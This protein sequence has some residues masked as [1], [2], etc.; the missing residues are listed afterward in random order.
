MDVFDVP[1]SSDAKFHEHHH[2]QGLGSARLSV[3]TLNR[4]SGSYGRI[5]LVR[6]RLGNQ[7]ILTHPRNHLVSAH[8]IHE[9]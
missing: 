6:I 7:P 8:P 5:V 3:D 9:H 1:L 4:Q 2:I